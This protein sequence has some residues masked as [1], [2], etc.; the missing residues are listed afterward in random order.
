VSSVKRPRRTRRRAQRRERGPRAGQCVF[1]SVVSRLR[2]VTDSN[3]VRASL[4][5]SVKR[6]VGNCSTFRTRYR[7]SRLTG[8]LKSSHL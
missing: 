4:H 7:D 1:S 6:F 3:F 8:L 2:T 5:G